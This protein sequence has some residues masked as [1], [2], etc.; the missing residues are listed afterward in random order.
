MSRRVPPTW[1]HLRGRSRSSWTAQ[2]KSDTGVPVGT[3]CKQ[4]SD[5]DVWKAGSNG[6][7]EL[8]GLVSE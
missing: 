1:K 3:S 4:G 7:S 5:R 6:S 2:L 8:R